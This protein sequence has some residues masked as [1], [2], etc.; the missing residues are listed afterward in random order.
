MN[1]LSKAGFNN[2]PRL[3]WGICV[4]TFIVNLGNYMT[5]FMS[6]YLSFNLGISPDL[7]GV[8]VSLAGLAFLP[9]SLIG[10]KLV[11]TW[12]K[13]E[14]FILFQLL[15]MIV[16]VIHIFVFD[17]IGTPVLFILNSFFVAATIPVYNSTIFD[18]SNQSNMKDSLSAFFIGLNIGNVFSSLIGAALFVRHYKLLFM[19]EALMKFFSLVIFTVFLKDISGEFQKQEQEAGTSTIESPHKPSGFISILFQTPI[20]ILFSIVCICFSVVLSQNNYA[21]PLHLNSIFGETGTSYYGVLLAINA[22][23]IALFTGFINNATKKKPRLDLIL[24]ACTFLGIGVV[25]MF[26]GRALWF[27][28]ISTITWSLADILNTPNSSA[29]FSEYAPP[30]MSGRFAAWIKIVTGAGYAVGPILVGFIISRYNTT[31]VWL[32][33]L[34]FILISILVLCI[35]RAADRRNKQILTNKGCSK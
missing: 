20:L 17:K 35:V 30:S 24:I 12:G 8:Y 31:L 23:T 15:A 9:G 13:R 29:Y 28:A 6:T 7:S 19:V 21:L 4:V 5:P 1:L 2:I 22:F 16:T 14:V 3:V 34:I 33:L 11:D 26:L 25:M 18:V 27:F 10:G 32:F